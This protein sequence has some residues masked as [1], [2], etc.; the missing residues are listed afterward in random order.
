MGNESS[1]LKGL[2]IDKKSIEVTDFW[3]LYSGTIPNGEHSTHIAIFQAEPVVAGQLW[4]TKSPLE[5]ATKNLMIYRHPSILRFITAWEKG[6]MRFLATEPCRPL[7]LAVSSQ[8]DI[9]V[10]LGLRNI[11]CS[12]IFLI[13]RANVRHLNVCLASVYVTPNGAW[14]LNGFEHLWPT[15]EVNATLLERSKSYRY[16]A[17]VDPNE[18]KREQ[19]DGLEQYS[20]A[21]LCEEVLKHPKA[22]STIP[23]V[24]EFRQY[25]VEHLCHP[26]VTMRPKLSAVLLH[27]YFNHEFVLIHSYLTELPLKTPLEKQT[28]FTSLID[29][30]RDFDEENVAI[31]LTDLMLSR[32]VVLDDTAKLC[33]IPFVLKPRTDADAA[34]ST[35]P[36]LFSIHIFTKYIIPKV[37]QLFLV[38]DSQIRLILL[39]YFP[40]YVQYFPSKDQ[41][42]DDILPQLLLGIREGN[43][44]TIVA[45]TLRALADLI[46]ILGSA[47]V[48]GRNRGRLFAD[49]R[50]NGTH[51]KSS[52]SSATASWA[53][54]PRSITP[55]INAVAA[56]DDLNGSPMRDAV[57]ISDS[58]VSVL[59]SQ[60]ASQHLMPERLSPDG[61]EDVQTASEQP[62]IEDDGW[63]DWETDA[64]DNPEAGTAIFDNDAE[65]VATD[66]TDPTS[67]LPKSVKLSQPTTSHANHTAALGPQSSD[68]SNTFI[69]DV[70]ELDIRTTKAPILSEIDDFLKDM[71]PVIAP[72]SSNG[73]LMNGDEKVENLQRISSNLMATKAIHV[74]QTRFAIKQMTEDDDALAD[75]DAWG[76]DDND[77]DVEDWMWINL[78]Y[79]FVWDKEW[80]KYI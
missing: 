52:A 23:N 64:A 37:Q 62:D 50:P 51:D 49:G 71:E 58:Y 66:E 55:L 18:T 59:N 57:D 42:I 21:V 13:E 8:T 6:S 65:I 76:H 27:P 60:N 77:W 7:S 26:S 29:R 10:C 9:Q 5:R 68:I 69:K 35:P 61:G 46:P 16:K 31:Q 47:V 24:A 39:E 79:V 25:C 74:D 34:S 20:F 36:P 43:N 41:L 11:L 38:R 2:Q 78:S 22:T 40:H 28:F 33:A 3:S 54:A 1:Q 63:S 56:S 53:S 17:A 32:M 45:M 72:S 75:S 44:E 4:T 48:I 12:L 30:L 70:K 73:I 14:R 80:C 67:T 15:K 19:I